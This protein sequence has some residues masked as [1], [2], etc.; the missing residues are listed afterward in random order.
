MAAPHVTAA[1]TYLKT[2]HPEWSPATIKSALM[3]TAKPMKVEPFEGALA[4][5]VCSTL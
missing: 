4:Y 2:F 3:T 1:M 5:Q